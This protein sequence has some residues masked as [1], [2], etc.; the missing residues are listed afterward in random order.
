MAT[1]EW[2]QFEAKKVVLKKESDWIRDLLKEEPF[3]HVAKPGVV[4]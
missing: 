1:Y 4:Y 3:E 2:F